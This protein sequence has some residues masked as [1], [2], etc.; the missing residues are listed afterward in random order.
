[1]LVTK[2]I[3]TPQSARPQLRLGGL[4]AHRP[5]GRRRVAAVWGYVLQHK[6]APQDRA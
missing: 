6:V 5:V 4:P 3:N 2:D 1:V